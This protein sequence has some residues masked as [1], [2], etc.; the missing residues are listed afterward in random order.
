[1]LTVCQQT[2]PSSHEERGSLILPYCSVWTR[3]ESIQVHTDFLP[4]TTHSRILSPNLFLRSFPVRSSLYSQ[5]LGG[6][7]HHLLNG[8]QK[9][10]VLA[11]TQ[12]L[13]FRQ[14]PSDTLKCIQHYPGIHHVNENSLVSMLRRQPLK[15]TIGTVAGRAIEYCEND[16]KITE[17]D[18]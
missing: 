13:S 12:C 8:L 9:H 17:E 4:T 1:M 10:H 2:F 6:S 16:F 3:K 18:L 15:T 14:S 7:R 11:Q 5:I